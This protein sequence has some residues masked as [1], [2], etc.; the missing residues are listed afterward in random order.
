M[1]GRVHAD[2]K[3]LVM[4]SCWLDDWGL[5]NPWGQKIPQTFLNFP[6]PR[7]PLAGPIPATAIQDDL[8][9]TN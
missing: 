6:L 3:T 7:G 5:G 2:D 4:S 1:P 8:R 9:I